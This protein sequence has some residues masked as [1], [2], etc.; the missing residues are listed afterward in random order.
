MYAAALAPRR[1][2]QASCSG[3]QP[4][5]LGVSSSRMLG[6]CGRGSVACSSGDNWSVSQCTT[7]GSEVAQARC[8]AVALYL[9]GVGA[10]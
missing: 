5:L 10:W 2:R 7:K 4:W 6:L 3:C 9:L 8:R 1:L